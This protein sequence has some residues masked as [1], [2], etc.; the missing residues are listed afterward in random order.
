VID[1]KRKLGLDLAAAQ[2]ALTAARTGNLPAVVAGANYGYSGPDFPPDN[3]SWSY[4]VSVQWPFFDSGATKGSIQQAQ[5]GLLS[6]Q[7]ALRQ[8][9]QTVGSE[10][11]Q[12][13]LN[14]QTAE[15]KVTAA[16]SEVANAQE[17]LNLATGR[18]Q[19]GVAA[20]IEV[21]DAE[22][23]LVTA[24]TNQVNALYS[25]STARAALKRALGLE[26]INQ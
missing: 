19:A 10:V 8:T 16:N 23:A 12:A 15:Q 9:E 13:Y 25:V 18:Y 2:Q 1:G 22:T 11:T 17:G 7:A 3:R 24:R 5:G 26:E 20:Y 21:I 4:S 6:A 14:V